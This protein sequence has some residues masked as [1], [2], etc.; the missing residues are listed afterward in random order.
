MVTARGEGRTAVVIQLTRGAG[1]LA[2]RINSFLEDRFGEPQ[3]L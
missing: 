3:E 1:E 2:E